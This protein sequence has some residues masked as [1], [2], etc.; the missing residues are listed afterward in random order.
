MLKETKKANNKETHPYGSVYGYPVSS[1]KPE[2]HLFLWGYFPVIRY[3]TMKTWA[4]LAALTAATSVVAGV[5]DLPPGIPRNRLEFR[6]KHPV[7]KRARGCRKTF[8][9][10]ASQHDLDDVSEEFEEAIRQAN[11][12]GTVY[13]PEGETFVIGKPLDLTFLNDVH[14]NLEGTIK[15]TNDTPYWQEHAFYHPFQRSLM[16]WKWGGKDIKIYGEGVLDGQGQR[17]W[18][19][20]SGQECVT[21]PWFLLHYA[22]SSG[23]AANTALQN[24]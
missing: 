19:E 15:F 3:P 14:V 8:T 20:F 16:F 4:V 1:D 5:V 11:N 6:Q 18:N 12:G 23:L 10:R 7:A 17:W 2:F 24:P 21:S 9:P 22:P 13:L